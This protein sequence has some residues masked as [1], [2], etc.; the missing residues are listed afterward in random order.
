MQILK[1]QPNLTCTATLL[2]FRSIILF[3][4]SLMRFEINDD[5]L[6]WHFRILSHRTFS[7]FLI[8]GRFSLLSRIIKWRLKTMQALCFLFFFIAKICLLILLMVWSTKSK[9]TPTTS[10]G[11]HCFP[12]DSVELPYTFSSY[13][14]YSFKCL[15]LTCF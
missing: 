6:Q 15:F 3:V 11:T 9:K 12:N 10:P 4:K 1:S 2:K 7:T 5:C 14:V 8:Y 13:K